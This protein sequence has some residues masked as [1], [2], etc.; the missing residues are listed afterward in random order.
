MSTTPAISESPRPLPDGYRPLP[1]SERRAVRNA[2]RV[3]AADPDKVLTVSVYVRRRPS[4]PPLAGQE[5]WMRTPPGHRQFLTREEMAAIHGAVQADLDIVSQFGQSHGLTVTDTSVARR[6]V[7]LSGTVRQM[8][9]AFAVDLGQYESPVGSY[10]GREGPV[11]LPDYVADVVV[12][13]FGLDDRPM[14]RRAS[15]GTGPPGASTLTPPQ[16]AKLY[17]LPVGS[18]AG[19]TIGVLVFG[20]GYDL[21]DIDA[22]FA[23]LNQTTPN[24]HAVSVGGVTNSP[25]GDPNGDD[26]EVVM[27]IDVAGS[28]G[29]GA[30]IAV[31]FASLTDQ[32]W[33]D[34]VTAAVLEPTALPAGWAAPSVLTCSWG[35]TELEA[36]APTGDAASPWSFEWTKQAINLLSGTFQ[37][38]AMMGVT[39]FNCSFDN[40]SNGYQN[41]GNA[42]VAYP[43]SDKWV[44][45]CGGTRI[46]NVAGSAFTESTWNDDAFQTGSATGG[47]ISDAI[48]L[49]VWQQNIVP[50]SVNA[51]GRI[52]RG[53]PDI[54]G[55]ASYYSGYLLQVDGK[56]NVQNNGTSSVAPLYAGL[57]AIINATLGQPVGYLNPTLYAL[58]KNP[59]YA[60]V[61]RDIN[62]GISNAV[63]WVNQ[64]G[65]TG[66]PSPGYTSGAGWDA[67]TGLGVLDGTKLLAALQ[68]LAANKVAPNSTATNAPTP[69]TTGTRTSPG[70][71]VP[72]HG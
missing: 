69:G 51:G 18:A 38:A 39:V 53:L 45:A 40:G 68:S 59:A 50:P 57:I 56:P 11:H 15:T 29:V 54:A 16:V 36:D 13:V 47:G 17:N 12:G 58:A 26:G 34:V 4:A 27:D 1:G 6:L 25:I 5:H 70:P 20:G 35:W 30:N 10:R 46:T 31:Y 28:V 37:Q 67:C 3:N 9:D 72:Q 21:T 48:D 2:Q 7:A 62:D 24:I 32:G 64:D 52:G 63:H 44:T 71:A 61:I 60:G 65:T 8:N 33:A 14:A 23:G 55:N 66:R 49:P 43:S 22:F 42:H 19:Q 41:D